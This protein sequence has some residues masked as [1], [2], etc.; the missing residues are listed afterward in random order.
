M[1]IFEPSLLDAPS[2]AADSDESVGH[3]RDYLYMREQGD[4]SH[5]FPDVTAQLIKLNNGRPVLFSPAYEAILV[6]S[7][8]DELE[9]DLL[10]S[11]MMDSSDS[12]SDLDD[13]DDEG[14]DF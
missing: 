8:F 4:P 5:D 9:Q 1:K 7:E 2:Q 13:D 6:Q 10:D 14:D 11:F 12:D 3:G